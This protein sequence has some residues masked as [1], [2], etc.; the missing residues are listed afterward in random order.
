MSTNAAAAE[1][2][3]RLSG[4][5]R[6]G[7]LSGAWLLSG[8]TILSGVFAYAFHILAART[9]GPEAYGRIA[10]LWGAM[11]LCAIVLF[12]PIEQTASRAI[13]DRLARG[14]GARSVISSATRVGVVALL[15]FAAALAVAWRPVSEG[16]FDG[17]GL[18][19]AMLLAG[20]AAYG[21][22]YLARGV[23]GGVRWFAGYG[24]NLIADG[25]ARLVVAIPLVAVA[26]TG[27]A[28]AAMV[29]A[30][31]AGAAV[32]LALGRHQVRAALAREAPGADRFRPRSTL[33]FAAP[34][35]V[36]AGADQILV[37]GSP[38]LVVLAGGAGA[39]AAAGVVFAATMLVR[40]P[41][42][43]FQ[44]AAASILPNLTR[45]HVTDDAAGF[46]AAVRKAIGVLGCAAVVI[47]IGAVA[48]GPEAM[49]V[50][51]GSEFSA[52]RVELGLLAI[53]VGA[54]LT[55]STISQGLLA[56]DRGRA[57]AVAWG[58]AAVLFV[59]L[60]LVLPGSELMRISA[61]FA[62]GMSVGAALTALSLIR[63]PR[64]A[65]P[66]LPLDMEDELTAK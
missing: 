36:I 12:R 31:L 28:G 41:V 2:R 4:P 65:A 49:G 17:D 60:H 37:N 22:S 39:S 50:I 26:S 42:F 15:L 34:A 8:A 16:L 25:L 63:R 18:L 58:S 7:A 57:A 1:S 35:V 46:R 10:V 27:L 43:V 52:S 14:V 55:A 62:I 3:A 40:V 9:L 54:Y 53:G 33:A 29:L 23:L 6:R 51:Y 45:L 24:L 13:A 64:G 11:F 20:T 61:A 32:P 38:I 30:G 66:Q 56:Q 5:P 19:T 59:A 44:G 21:L 47:A 48:I